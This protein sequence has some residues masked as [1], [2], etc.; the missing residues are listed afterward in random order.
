[1]NYVFYASDMEAVAAKSHLRKMDA[2]RE[3][4]N[5]IKR[6]LVNCIVEK[7]TSYDGSLIEADSVGIVI[8][9]YRW[10]I[11][12]PVYAF[13][14]NLRIKPGTYVYVTIVGETLSECAVATI[15]TRM[16]SIQ[17]LKKQLIKK[18]IC[19]ESN[20]YIRCLDAERSFSRVEETLKHTSILEDKIK[21]IMSGLLMYSIKALKAVEIVKEESKIN[22]INI[23][24]QKVKEELNAF[25][26]SNVRRMTNIF[27]D[28]DIMAGV[29][30]CRAQ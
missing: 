26:R 15:D 14:N 13:I 25:E 21:C 3:I 29:R 30:L 28:D 24:R 8:P 7:Y 12:M 22:S 6:G 5:H 18:G 27:L 11:S 2:E 16:N 23:K 20:I 9:A 17:T 19:D 4:A 1:M 10:G